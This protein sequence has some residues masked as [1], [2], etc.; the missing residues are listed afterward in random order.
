[1]RRARTGFGIGTSRVNVQRD[2]PTPYGWSLGADDNGP[3]YGCADVTR[4]EGEDGRPIVVLVNH[5]VQS[6]AM[7]GSV[8]Q[9]GERQVTA[10]LAGATN[11]WM[12]ESVLPASQPV[13]QVLSATWVFARSAL[14]NLRG[15]DRRGGLGVGGAAAAGVVHPLRCPSPGR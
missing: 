2:M 9:A 3:V 11:R 12:E 8:T 13:R 1:M 7:N 14:R 15:T 10:D 6:S 5:A 4:I